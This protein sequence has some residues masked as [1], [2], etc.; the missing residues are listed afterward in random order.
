MTTLGGTIALPDG[1]LVRGNLSFTDRIAAIDPSSSAGDDYILPGFID[2]QVNG[3]HGI[4]VMNASPESLVTLGLGTSAAKHS[5]FRAVRKLRVA[6]GP[7]RG[8][9]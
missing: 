2:L 7:M 9:S 8:E 5:V 3:S 1:S 6:L 4:D